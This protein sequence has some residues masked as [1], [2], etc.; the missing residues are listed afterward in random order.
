MPPYGN[1]QAAGF[2]ETLTSALSEFVDVYGWI[3]P[4]LLLTALL[5]AGIALLCFF[6]DDLPLE[7]PIIR[8]GRRI[9]RSTRRNWISA[10]RSRYAGLTSLRLSGARRASSSARE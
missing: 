3:L 8:V 9:F 5:I 7:V 4:A 10:R 2:W 1:A 6:L